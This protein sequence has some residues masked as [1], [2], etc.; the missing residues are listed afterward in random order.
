[1]GLRSEIL[2]PLRCWRFD[3]REHIAA[4]VA[5]KSP[6]LAGLIAVDLQIVVFHRGFR[7]EG[8]GC[9]ALEAQFDMV[10]EFADGCGGRAY[11]MMGS[12]P[13][14]ASLPVGEMK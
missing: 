6:Q 14:L 3:S 5:D 1:M 4:Q 13:V 2:I 9:T 12:A 11:R 7:L 8:V 10:G